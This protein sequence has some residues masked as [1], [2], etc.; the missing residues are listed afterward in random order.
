M[1]RVE[2]SPLKTYMEIE[3]KVDSGI[4]SEGFSIN[5]EG[6]VYHVS[7]IYEMDPDG[8]P[9]ITIGMFRG[10][11]KSVSLHRKMM[12]ILGTFVGLYPL[13]MQMNDLSILK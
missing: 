10:E 12:N 9:T 13:H 4:M 7:P 3:I 8:W 6:V 11:Y 2:V 1:K 5:V